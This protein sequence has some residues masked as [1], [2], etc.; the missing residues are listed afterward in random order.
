M[1]SHTYQATAQAALRACLLAFLRFAW[2]CTAFTQ[3]SKKNRMF[4]RFSQANTARRT[5]SSTGE[6]MAMFQWCSAV[7][8][9]CFALVLV[10]E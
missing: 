4:A 6:A 3:Q 7:W 8:H 10:Q 1:Q 2:P 5:T 9:N